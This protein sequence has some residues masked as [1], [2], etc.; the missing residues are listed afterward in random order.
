MLSFEPPQLGLD[1]FRAASA[2]LGFY[3]LEEQTLERRAVLLVLAGVLVL[4]LVQEGAVP[5]V[6]GGVAV[7]ER[8]RRPVTA[9]DVLDVHLAKHLGRG[10]GVVA[11]HGAQLHPE[12]VRLPLVVPAVARADG[13]PDRRQEAHERQRHQPAG[14]VEGEEEDFQGPE[15]GLERVHLGRVPE[16]Q[17]GNLVSQHERELVLAR[18]ELLEHGRGDEDAPREQLRHER[19]R[20]RRGDQHELPRTLDVVPG[21]RPAVHRFVL[22][23]RLV[24]LP[25]VGDGLRGQA[26]RRFL[27]R[28]GEVRLDVLPRGS[29]DLFAAS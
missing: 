8:P 3:G 15:G 27:D 6:R 20:D 13:R 17:V 23:E 2:H 22:L 1:F 25:V 24:Q 7:E 5:L 19:V 18:D 4:A 11:R 29:D 16:D 26:A 12:L 9:L 28:V 21:L 14:G 10:A